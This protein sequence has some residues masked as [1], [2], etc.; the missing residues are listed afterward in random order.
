[1][2]DNIIFINVT[3]FNI[4]KGLRMKYN[5]FNKKIL[6][7]GMG[8]T[9]ISCLKFFLQKGIHPKIM[10]TNPKPKSIK[11]I[12]QFKN[13]NYHLGSINYSW[14]SESELIIVSP[15]I[16]L[17]HPALI[18]AKKLGIEI[19]GDIEIFV[20]E[21]NLPIIAITGSNGKSTVTKM[22]ESIMQTAGFQVC[23]GG[24]IGIPVLNIVHKKPDFFLLELS[25]FQ[26]ETTFNLKAT[27][28][29]ILNISPDHINRYPL[30]IKQYIR[31]KQKIFN[32]AKTCII[33]SNNKILFSNEI[34]QRSLITFG[35]HQG[36]YHLD[37]EKNSIWLSYKS[38]K[39]L[40][41][42]KLQISGKHNY[43]NALSAL[44][45]VHKLNINFKT[46]KK[47]L[48]NFKGL[49]H[50]FEIAYKQKNIIWI[51]DS[52]STNIGSTIEAIKNVMHTKKNIRL[53]LGG[54]G[55]S[56]DFSLLKPYLTS[57]KI[58][59]YCFGKNRKEIFQ[60]YPNKTTCVKTL[61]DVITLIKKHI[62]KEEIILLSPAC[63]SLDQFSSYKERGNLFIQLIKNI[64]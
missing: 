24:N 46:C 34:K 7:F 53:I 37:Y 9:G 26:L 62:K 28:A 8:L 43:I 48:I 3:K 60:L 1:M 52:K 20:R 44:S 11:T 55:K 40:N 27:L 59:I 45:I 32:H 63:S 41:V 57:K 19:I 49:P 58:T 13:I 4:I 31:A 33:N 12:L 23:T 61:L 30:G 51:N 47:A 17:Y 50:R 21:T 2:L 16:S 35:A 14:I 42:R 10:D 56:T 54:D 25:S 64:I 5:Y 22:V 36:D 29:T 38:I 39:I 6:I 18:Y 15:G